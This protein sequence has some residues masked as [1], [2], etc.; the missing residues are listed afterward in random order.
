MSTSPEHSSSSGAGGW[1]SRCR[2]VQ[3]LYDTYFRSSE[4]WER[5]R[6]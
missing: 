2:A 3:E 6:Q 4:P 5:A 1:I